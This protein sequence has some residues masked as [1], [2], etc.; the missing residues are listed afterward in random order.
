MDRGEIDR[1]LSLGAAQRHILL[2]WLAG[3]SDEGGKAC[4]RR[5]SN[6]HGL[7]ASGF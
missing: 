2:Y 4:R 1:K 5:E 7:A 6:P 3:P